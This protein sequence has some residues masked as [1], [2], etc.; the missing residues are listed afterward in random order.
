MTIMSQTDEDVPAADS[1]SVLVCQ[2]GV[3]DAYF[4]ALLDVMG[5]PIAQFGWPLAG[6]KDFAQRLLTQ[7]AA[8]EHGSNLE[9]PLKMIA[10]EMGAPPLTKTMDFEQFRDHFPTSFVINKNSTDPDHKIITIQ[11]RRVTKVTRA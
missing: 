4:I 7:V 5:K 2:T 1:V 10:D 11:V 9:I 3:D 6:W 8:F